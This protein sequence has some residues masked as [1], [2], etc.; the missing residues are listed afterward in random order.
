MKKLLLSLLTLAFINT[1][2]AQVPVINWHD[3]IGGT[4]YEKATAVK[5]TTDG[6]YIISG[7][8]NSTLPGLVNKGG[9]DML[10]I[11]LNSNGSVAWEKDYGGYYEDYANNIIQTPDG[12]YLVAG[13]TSSDDG[14]VTTVNNTTDS[15]FRGEFWILKLDASGNIT[16][17]KVYGG[18]TA[19]FA[20]AVCTTSDG[21]YMV[22]GGTWYS[23]GDVGDG[24]G[25]QDMWVTKLTSTG[26]LMWQ[27][28]YGGGYH[29]GANA[30]LQTADGGYFLAGWTYSG[31]LPGF[32]DDTTSAVSEDG[33]LVK[34]DDTGGLQWQKCIGSYEGM[35][36]I[37]AAQNTAD[38]NIILAGHAGFNSGDVTGNHGANDFWMVKI[39]TAG[40]ILWQKCYGGSEHNEAYDVRQTLD[41]GYVLAGVANSN[42]S[43][44]VGS[45]GENE[46]WVVKTN[47]TGTLQWQVPL[48]CVNDDEGYAICQSADSSYVV[49]GLY[50]TVGPDVT[51]CIFDTGYGDKNLWI[52][53]L[54]KDT[55]A[56]SVQ[57]INTNS[58]SIYPDPVQDRFTIAFGH[59][60]DVSETIIITDAYG[61][62]IR[63]T[64][65][66]GNS[67]KYD[68][69]I[70]DFPSGIYIVKVIGDQVPLQAKLIKL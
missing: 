27:K 29:D 21:G 14:D 35:E 13:S 42:D 2:N 40:S 34:T 22:A 23:G 9:H 66:N 25:Y 33:Y 30:V 8:T 17:Q 38:G 6:G 5:P 62:E 19:T 16:W 61:K 12:G 49:A 51:G 39:T 56:L 3:E 44:V 59:T 32:H 52:V 48:G 4:G 15:N 54:G 1:A 50:G 26:D 67:Q 37:A 7:Y 68:E 64:T 53:K 70:S 55:T 41:G 65:I 57:T 69:D 31:D 20:N 24:F 36:E 43:D 28:C 60:P 46:M 47:G 10:I 45:H 18:S 11:K 63:K 58:L